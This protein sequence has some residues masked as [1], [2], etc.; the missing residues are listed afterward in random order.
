M[1]VHCSHAEQDVC[2]ANV[3]WHDVTVFFS[4]TFDFLYSLHCVLKSLHSWPQTEGFLISQCTTGESSET[5]SS[6]NMKHA[7]TI[8][9]GDHTLIFINVIEPERAMNNLFHL[10][11]GGKQ[12]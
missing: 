12:M 9:W 3:R 5:I 6:P 11:S 7:Y 8:R 4:A 2:T 10:I 1:A